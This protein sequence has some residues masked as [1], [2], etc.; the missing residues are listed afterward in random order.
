MAQSAQEI[1]ELFRGLQYELSLRH[2]RGT[3]LFK[4]EQVG[5]WYMS[6]DHGAISLADQ[7]REAQCTFSFT[8]HDFIDIVEGRRNLLTAVLQGRVQVSGD[9]A[10]AQSFQHFVSTLAERTRGAA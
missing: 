10:L 4:I 5:N 2:V 9:L 1:F 7:Q 6:V 3:Y 8:E